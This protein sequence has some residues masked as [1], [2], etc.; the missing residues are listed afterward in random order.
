MIGLVASLTV[1]EGKGPELEAIFRELTAQVKANEP[2]CLTYQLIHHRK[3]PNSYRVIEFY[4]DDEALKT[5]MESAHFQAA[6]PKIGATLDGRPLLE[7]YD[8]VE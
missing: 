4:R 3:E 5:H 8:A 7:K 2:G 1:Q 6:N